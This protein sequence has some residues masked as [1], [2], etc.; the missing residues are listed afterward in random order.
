LVN[1]ID[2][3]GA[4]LFAA[5]NNGIFISTDDGTSWASA[6]YN[7]NSLTQNTTFTNI[8]V[9][10]DNI[11]ASISLFGGVTLTNNSKRWN[12]LLAP[13]IAV[14][15]FEV[16]GD[17]LFEGSIMNAGIMYTLITPTFAED[18]SNSLPTCF[19]LEQNYPNPF[20]PSTKISYQL[21][22]RG[23]VT[24][25]VF[26]SLGEEIRTLIDEQKDAGNYEIE[27]NASDLPSGIYIYKINAGNYTAVKKMILLK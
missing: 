18:K 6:N 10:G 20:N 21:P 24:L 4:N 13:F 17:R 5:T 8:D 2:F 9:C 7:L 14:G 25:R 26:N 15:G 27:F 12:D 16:L 11:Y 23:N 3:C 22:V 19:T 1:D